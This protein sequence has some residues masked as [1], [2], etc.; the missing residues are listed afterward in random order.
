[1]ALMA[2]NHDRVAAL[3]GQRLPD[4]I[5]WPE[6]FARLVLIRYSKRLGVFDAAVIG[7]EFAEQNPN[8]RRLAGAIWTNN[9]DTVPT[10]DFERQIPRDNKRAIRRIK[11]L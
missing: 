10:E 2:L 5:L 8:E 7:L 9:P 1:M 6:A 11:R 4:C 3:R